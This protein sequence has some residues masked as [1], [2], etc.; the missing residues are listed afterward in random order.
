M[1]LAVDRDLEKYFFML[2]KLAEVGALGRTVKVSTEALAEK[3]EV[4]QQTVSR[5]LIELERIGWIQRTATRDGSFIKI[6]SSGETHLRSVHAGLKRIFEE[7]YPPAITIEGTVFSGLGEGAYYVTQEPYRKQFA[8]KLG[9]EPYPGTLNLRVTGEY[10]AKMRSELD[11][12][13]GVEIKGFKNE[14]RTYGSVKCFPATINGKEKGAVI[15][16]LRSHYDSS[17]V[18]AIAPV[19]LR[20]RLKLRNGNK[21]KLEI[22][23]TKP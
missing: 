9:F 16:A 15:R 13:P 4:S 22:L 8:E 21:V 23:L 20:D 7:G 5:Q 1:S 10:Y 6:S 14:D 19:S 11:A 3:I 12:S 18:E 2:Y 17:V